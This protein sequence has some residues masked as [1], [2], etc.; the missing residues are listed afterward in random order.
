MSEVK[1]VIT[2]ADRSTKAMTAAAAGLA[3]VASDLQTLADTSASLAQEIEFKQSDLD[4]LSSQFDTRFR[5]ATAELKLKVIEDEDKV[6][7]SI[8][9][10]RGLVTIA[11]TELTDLQKQLQVA[12]RDLTDELAAAT[13]EGH[14]TAAIS[15][16]AAK[17]TLEAEHRVTL[18]QHEANARSAQDRIAFLTEQNESL[19]G[20]ITAERETRLEIA[21]ADASRQGVTVNN[22]K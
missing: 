18:A 5:E 10:A 12:Q 14:R 8:L 7:A 17:S 15:H 2:V 20:Q 9:K 11:P 22:G 4:N 13:A 1:K 3:K 16:N 6:L 21:K 19:K